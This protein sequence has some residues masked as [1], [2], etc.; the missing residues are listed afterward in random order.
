MTVEEWCR[1]L[2]RRVF[3]WVE[4]ERVERLLGAR[5]YRARAHDVLTVDTAS[6]V[7]AHG[8]EI[9]LAHVNTGTTLFQAPPRGS[10]TFRS[11]S[12]YDFAARSRVVELAVDYSV[13]NLVPHT[14]LVESRQGPAVLETIWTP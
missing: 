4:E 9:T 10:D 13:A 7:A 2:K 12:E 5:A 3:F 14:L 8:P 11:I 6:L 1:E